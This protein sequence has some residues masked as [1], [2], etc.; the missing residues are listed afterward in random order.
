MYATN[1]NGYIGNQ[2]KD[3]EIDMEWDDF[4]WDTGENGTD[5]CNWFLLNKRE[6]RWTDKKG[7][8][9][10]LKD[11]D[12]DYLANII[13]LLKKKNNI[14]NYFDEVIKFLRKEQKRRSK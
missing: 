2:R 8:D 6:F 14:E 3:K 7:N 9:H 1:N 11:I 13:A 10:K 5:Y 4:D 12:N